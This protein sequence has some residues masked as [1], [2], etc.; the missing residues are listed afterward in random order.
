MLIGILV[1][2]FVLVLLLASCVSLLSKM[3]I[4]R[5]LLAYAVGL[6]IVYKVY[7]V[8]FETMYLRDNLKKNKQ[9]VANLWWISA[10]SNALRGIAT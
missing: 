6:F 1:A 8:V 3:S 9:H 7:A 10:Y 4:E 2:G 5:Q